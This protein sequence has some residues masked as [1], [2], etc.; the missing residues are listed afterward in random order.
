MRIVDLINKKKHGES[1]TK[2]EIDYFI[3]GYTKGE[4]PDYQISALL[5]AIY[6]K[7]METREIAD[8]TD[9]MVRSGDTV[10]LSRIEGIKVDKHSTGGV[11]DK[12]S[13][14]VI[15][16]VASVGVPVAKMSGRGLGH[17]GGTIDKLE[18]IEGFKVELSNEDFINNVNTYKMAIVGQS[19]NLT[20]A[21]KKLYALRDVT[22][23]I[24]SIPLIASSIMSKKIAAGTDAIV[25]DVK[26][27]SGA[28]MKSLEDA[29]ELAKTMVEIGKSLHRKTVAVITNMDQPLGHEVGNANEIKEAIDVLSG[30]GAED[31]TEVALTIASY[32]AVLGGAF[33]NNEDARKHFEKIIASG[34]AI[35]ILKKFV[36]IQ[37]GN[38]EVIAHPE[39]LPQ[40]SRHIEVKADLEGFVGGFDSEKVGISAMML[41]AGRRKKEDSIDYAAGITIKK[42]LGDHVNLGDVLCVLHTNLEDVTEA[43]RVVRSAFVISGHEPGAIK[44]IYEIIE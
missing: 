16:L 4:I 35:E 6:F 8:L 40:A 5:M 34:E 20:P 43:E 12:I 28:F 9:A 37:G 22:G 18:S 44:Y 27:G 24:D 32:M 7:G 19:G 42:K 26:V 14:I 25:L 30:K 21:D 15:P 1:L 36:E 2:A 10:D 29:R 11:G 38:P 13:L 3:S 31:E 23:T 39:R 17:T 33:K 41:G